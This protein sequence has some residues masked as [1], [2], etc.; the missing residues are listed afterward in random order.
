MLLFVGIWMQR[1][2]QVGAWQQYV[3]EQIGAVLSRRSAW[4]LFLL[5]DEAK[6]N[7]SI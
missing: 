1:K 3:K 2:S 5:F 4:F 7:E 6:D